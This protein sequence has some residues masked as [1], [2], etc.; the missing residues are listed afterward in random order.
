MQE[1]PSS[2]LGGPTIFMTGYDLETI[3]HSAAHVMASAV[4]RIWPG[5]K[6]GIGPAVEDGFYY[7][8]LLPEGVK[9]SDADLQRIED[10]M[11]EIIAKDLPFERILV[12]KEEARQI[13]EDLGEVFKIELIDEIPEDFVSIYKHGDFVDLCRGPHIS[14]TKLVG[15][16]RLLKV[17][18]AYWKGI[19][20]NPMLTRIYGTA[21]ETKEDLDKYLKF[22]EEAA[23]RDH[24]RIGTELG[25]FSMMDEYGPGLV[26]WHPKG[27]MV[28]KVIEDFWRS[29]HI[30]NGYDLVFT[31]HIA[32]LDLW[33]TSGHLDFYRENMYTPMDVDGVEY[34]LK[35]M[36]CPFHILIYKSRLRSYREF[37]MRFAE[38][39]TVYRYE[40]SGVLHGLM[41][42]RGFTQ[43]D[44][45]IFCT[46]EQ[47]NK[48][49]KGVLD[50][51]LFM[52]KSFGFSEFDV[53][54][55][56]KPEKYVGSDENWELATSALTAALDD[57][58]I[59]WSVDEGEGVFYGPKID[60]KIKDSI[61]RKWQCST[62][63]VDFNLPERFDIYYVESDGQ[64]TRPIMIH[65]ALMGSLERF[66]GVLIEHF[67]GAFP[68]WLAPVQ[69]RIL[70]IS[71][72][73]IDYGTSVFDRL[74]KEGFRA[75]LDRR[76][77]KLGLKIRE[78]ELEKI[79]YMVIIGDKEA[80]SGMLSVRSRMDGDLGA[81]TPD[82]FVGL[83]RE[84]VLNRN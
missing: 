49:I 56:T 81:K 74:L 12:S 32:R 54:L 26:L 34:E 51:S 39:G 70:T 73:H 2:I 18:G 22:L 42:V 44:A 62:I 53:R 20:S 79:P 8:F 11:N 29:E 19:E 43:D 4:K 16:V 45:H 10:V 3:R 63:Q 25:L 17:A 47:L 9:I 21:F 66:F 57:S 48:E 41:R 36:N 82:D 84:K 33:K 38:L 27:A 78:A 60:I 55:S 1:V 40:R 24:R 65:R 77:E 80:A 6:L 59:E 71:D 67:A 31:P 30:K 69:V 46:K 50:L 61:G 7:D 15:A 68:V 13:F 35:P 83:L 76:N 5:T 37:P 64:R 58:N 23:R 75:E 14:S 72:K 52:L 28:R